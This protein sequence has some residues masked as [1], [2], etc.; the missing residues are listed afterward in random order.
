MDFK[1]LEAYSSVVCA[2][3]VVLK[4]E[5]QVKSARIAW[6]NAKKVSKSLLCNVSVTLLCLSSL[7]EMSVLE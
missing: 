6:G 1:Q 4:M 2:H 5:P 3:F 7:L